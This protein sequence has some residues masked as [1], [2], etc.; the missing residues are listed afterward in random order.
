MFCTRPAFLARGAQTG[1]ATYLAA[2]SG[3]VRRLYNAEVEVNRLLE[4]IESLMWATHWLPGETVPYRWTALLY[5]DASNRCLFQFAG[6]SG[7]AR[8][9]RCARISFALHYQG[10]TSITTALDTSSTGGG[11]PRYAK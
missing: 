5:G 3:P 11:V 6:L 9:W 4:P 10:S 7:G 2:S 1:L 8:S